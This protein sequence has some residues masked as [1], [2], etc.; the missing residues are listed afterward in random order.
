MNAQHDV[1]ARLFG[2]HVRAQVLRELS[3]RDAAR[4]ADLARTVDHGA[5][6]HA[7]HA[8][9]D[10]GIVVK[11][12]GRYCL[13]PA[14]R[15]TPALRTFFLA[16]APGPTVAVGDGHG[17]LEPTLFG[18]RSCTAA[19]LEIGSETPI[20]AKDVAMRSGIRLPKVR[21]IMERLRAVGVVAP[22]E[23]IALDPR[24][25]SVEALRA[26]IDACREPAVAPAIPARLAALFRSASFYWAMRA[27]AH[28]KA[29]A[30]SDIAAAGLQGD[31]HDVAHD[32]VAGGVAVKAMRGN[33]AVY[34]LNPGM[35]GL[36]QFRALLG[37]D[38][39]SLHGGTQPSHP[40]GPVSTGV[41]RALAAGPRSAD[42]IAKSTRHARTSIL[43]HLTHLLKAGIVERDDGVFSIAE[44]PES[45]ELRAFLDALAP[46]S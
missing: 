7:L 13:D 1:V 46:I 41:L 36:G 16:N 43:A 9:L 15:G 20:A 11:H 2:G 30:I 5:L 8:L 35:R 45:A 25:P 24:F 33:R 26:L 31:P 21:R 38:S 14:F 18:R 3:R 42:Q 10:A 37:A 4:Y 22:G 40:F 12:D 44:F 17:L 27:M 19:L 28:G 29:L 23:P 6:T 39:G 32:L 34:A